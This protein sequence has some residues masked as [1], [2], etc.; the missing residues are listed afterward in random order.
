MQVKMNFHPMFPITPQYYVMPTQH[1]LFG[2]QLF[3]N[4]ALSLE[5]ESTRQ[6]DRTAVIEDQ[7]YGGRWTR[8]EDQRLR[9]G[10]ILNA[11]I[12]LR[13]QADYD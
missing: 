5:T 7:G 9:D 4:H 13:I 6:P 2:F 3:S 8:V 1:P 12:L 11:L 10:F